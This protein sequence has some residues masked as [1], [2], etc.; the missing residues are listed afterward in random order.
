MIGMVATGFRPPPH[1]YQVLFHTRTPSTTI[2]HLLL[3]EWMALPAALAARAQSSAP[4][5]PQVP[6]G[7]LNRSAPIT[8]GLL[9]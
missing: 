3:T 8:V 1:Q 2:S 9:P 5:V 6:E 4:L 7:S